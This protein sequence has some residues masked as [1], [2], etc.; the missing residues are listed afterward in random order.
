MDV[1][2]PVRRDRRARPPGRGPPDE[3]A[4]YLDQFMRAIGPGAEHRRAGDPACH[5]PRPPRRGLDR[6]RRVA[7]EAAVARLGGARSALG[8]SLGPARPGR[9]RT[10]ARIAM[11]T[12]WRSCARSAPPRRRSAASRCSLARTSWRAWRRVAAPSRSLAPADDPRVR[13]R[14]EDR[15]RADQRRARRRAVD[16]AEDGERPRRAHPGQA[17]CLA[18]RG[19]RRVGERGL[20]R[21]GQRH[22][23]GR[24]RSR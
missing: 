10:F 9:A 14:P 17:R 11:R 18:P 15:R 19:D 16:L 5:G 24:A 2:R 4:R 8:G 22:A 1:P 20:E 6:R 12:R 13:G 21:D 23:A 7:L 3:A